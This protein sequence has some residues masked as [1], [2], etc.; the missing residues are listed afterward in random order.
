MRIVIEVAKT[1]HAERALELLYQRTPMQSTFG[2]N[3]LALVDDEPRLLNLKQAL[4]VYLEHRLTVT[5]RRSDFELARAKERAHV[6]SG[7]RVALQHLDEVIQL[8]RGA[9]DP[10]QARLRLMKR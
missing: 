10:E 9:S 6:L 2:F 8:I 3:M 7:L 5:R 1:A 4:R